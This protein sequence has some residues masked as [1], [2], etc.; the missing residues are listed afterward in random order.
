M[1]SEEEVDQN[2]KL[3]LNNMLLFSYISQPFKEIE[4]IGM[5]RKERSA[6]KAAL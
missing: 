3:S 1:T 4:A 6:M 5:I 2:V